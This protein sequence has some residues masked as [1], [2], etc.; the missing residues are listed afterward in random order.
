[1]SF[2]RPKWGCSGCFCPTMSQLAASRSISSAGRTIAPCSRLATT[3]I[4]RAVAGI[5]PVTP[6]TMRGAVGGIAARRS[7]SARMTRLRRSTIES[8]PRSFMYAGQYCVTILRNSSVW[9]QCSANSSGTS[10]A[11]RSRLAPSVSTRSTRRASSAASLAACA[12]VRAPAVETGPRP[13]VALVAARVMTSDHFKTN[14]V[15]A[16]RRSISLM[17]GASP[18]WSV[19]RDSQTCTAGQQAQFLLTVTNRSNAGQQ[20]RCAARRAQ[21]RILNRARRSPRRQQQGVVRQIDRRW[22]RAAL[23][24]EIAVKDGARQAIE[25]RRPRRHVEDARVRGRFTG[26]RHAD[27]PGRL[28]PR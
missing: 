20:H 22:F 17:A 7:A 18:V 9:P 2:A 26:C 23:S 28:R 4:S 1:M 5:E 14:C 25:E 8:R 6:A 15:S 12:G 24:R 10:S 3:C 13:P 16:R 11:S 19:P 27:R 21:K